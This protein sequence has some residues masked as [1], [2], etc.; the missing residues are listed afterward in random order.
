MDKPRDII[1]RY[2]D[3]ESESDIYHLGFKY[4]SK[5]DVLAFVK[6]NGN[7]FQYA[8]DALKDDVEIVEAACKNTW[9]ALQYASKRFQK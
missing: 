2:S 9:I 6:K 8:S 4:A 1:E 3:R 7:D 5:E